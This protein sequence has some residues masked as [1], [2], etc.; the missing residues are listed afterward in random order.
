MKAC[1]VGLVLVIVGMMATVVGWG[2]HGYWSFV[3]G[4]THHPVTTETALQYA[5]FCL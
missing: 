2:M 5:E 3:A 1:G 4:L